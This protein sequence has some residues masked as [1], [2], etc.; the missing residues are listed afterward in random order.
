MCV[1]RLRHI[2]PDYKLSQP[3]HCR[4]GREMPSPYVNI[5]RK[6][7]SFETLYPQHNGQGQAFIG[8]VLVRD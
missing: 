7:L 4:N 6:E 5:K 8:I 1:R 3:L 2:R